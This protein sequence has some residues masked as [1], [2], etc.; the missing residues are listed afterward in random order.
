M[1]HLDELEKLYR[2]RG[3]TYSASEA[4]NLIGWAAAEIS[5]LRSYIWSLDGKIVGTRADGGA[6]LTDE[7]MIVASDICPFEQAGIPVSVL[8]LA[9]NQISAA[10]RPH[11]LAL[12]V[13]VDGN[14][15]VAVHD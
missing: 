7:G 9:I 3:D 8:K 12:M 5:R 4:V 10:I 2:L 15:S 6:S 11:G 14:Y 1:D 13:D